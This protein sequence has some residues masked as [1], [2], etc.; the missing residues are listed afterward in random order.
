M[1]RWMTA[2]I[3]AGLL[4]ALAP[5]AAG[6]AGSAGS[7]APV[8]EGT[9]VAVYDLYLGGIKAGEMVLGYWVGDATYRAE[10]VLQTSGLAALIYK[11]S[12]S[13]ESTGAV[14]EGVLA[15]ERFAAQSAMEDKAQWV[16]MTFGAAGPA[17]V[18]AEPPFVPKPWEVDPAAQT[19]ATDPI[20]AAISALAPRPV[21]EICN[22]TEDIFD[23]RRRYEVELGAPE[24][25]QGRIR[26]AAVYRRVAGF[27]PKLMD[28]QREF[29]FDIW[30][31]E[32]ADGLAHVKRAAGESIYGLVVLLARE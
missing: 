15:P 2:G 22:R 23:G 5:G 13:A 28:R 20:A 14:A 30:F 29:P 6:S 1:M 17:G 19:G 26:C 31:E 10:A 25:H 3:L 8:R 9:A 18:S 21:G 7:G 27:K 12:F 16:E 32:R 24:P 4:A 11:A